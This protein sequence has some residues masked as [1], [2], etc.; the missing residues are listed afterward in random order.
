MWG[1]YDEGSKKI[2]FDIS[3]SDSSGVSRR[4]EKY[5]RIAGIQIR[6]AKDR[7]HLDER[8]RAILIKAIEPDKGI[9][10]ITFLEDKK[11]SSQ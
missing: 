9:I 11:R 5:G 1:K 4:F 3:F 7:C 8:W 2:I 6:R 10:K